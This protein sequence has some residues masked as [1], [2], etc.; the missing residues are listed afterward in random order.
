[1]TLYYIIFL[2]FLVLLRASRLR[3]RLLA[4]ELQG[5]DRRYVQFMHWLLTKLASRKQTG[6]PRLLDLDP[7]SML[8]APWNQTQPLRNTMFFMK[9]QWVRSYPRPCPSTLRLQGSPMGPI[10]TGRGIHARSSSQ[11]TA[12][13]TRLERV[14]TRLTSLVSHPVVLP[15]I[16]LGCGV[17][18][19]YKRTLAP[20]LAELRWRAKVQDAAQAADT[21]TWPPEAMVDLQKAKAA[22]ASGDVELW[23]T[24]LTR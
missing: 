8:W 16:L 19:V 2:A 24:H 1:M 23:R 14:Q 21:Y 17:Y 6:V 5:V 3:W 12:Q 11:G 13:N 20:Q 4:T 10:R 18:A 7:Q 15:L 9:R 22:E